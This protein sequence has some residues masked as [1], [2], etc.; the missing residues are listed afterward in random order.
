MS[1]GAECLH[2]RGG[3]DGDEQPRWRGTVWLPMSSTSVFRAARGAYIAMHLFFG[4]FLIV[5]IYAGFFIHR[6]IGKI[7]A[8]WTACYAVVLYWL[9]R[10]EVRITDDELIFRSLFGERRMRHD[11]IAL[12]RLGFDLIQGGGPLRLLVESKKAPGMIAM[13]INAKVLSREAIRAV[14]DLG[15]RVARSDAGGL[16]DGLVI[17]AVRRR[18]SRKS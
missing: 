8:I 1:D 16:E 3:F 7:A 10:F 2:R 11:E 4:T 15:R 13:S 6:D 14:L 17:R 9:H 18:K 5:W 12:V